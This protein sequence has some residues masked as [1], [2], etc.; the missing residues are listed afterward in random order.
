ML[1][2]A[3]RKY[4]RNDFE[5]PELSLGSRSKVTRVFD[6]GR[7]LVSEVL[8]ELLR[9]DYR[10]IISKYGFGLSLNGTAELDE[11]VKRF[12]QELRYLYV[13]SYSKRWMRPDECLD[14]RSLTPLYNLRGL[15]VGY[16]LSSRNATA[17]EQLVNLEFL[18]LAWKIDEAV[19]LRKFQHLRELVIFASPQLESVW[20]LSSLRKLAISHHPE[21][22]LKS[23]SGLASIEKLTIGESTRFKSL[24]GIGN[25]HTLRFLGLFADNNLRNLAYVTGANSLEYIVIENCSRLE[26]IDELVELPNLKYL[27]VRGCPLLKS[28][29]VFPALPNLTH[30][31][32]MESTRPDRSIEEILGNLPNLRYYSNG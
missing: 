32:F 14:F 17:I 12:R 9:K 10:Y 5:A 1:V 13:H 28:V 24:R 20:K 3:I 23:A 31:F 22:N 16:M 15:S 18:S 26:N 21:T 7:V 25:L 19:D 29:N 8:Q 30:V 4:V 2:S 6:E 27:E 11:I